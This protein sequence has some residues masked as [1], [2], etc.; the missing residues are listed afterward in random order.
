MG[1]DKFL[2]AAVLRE[3]ITPALL[4]LS[5]LATINAA[6]FVPTCSPPFRW[7]AAGLCG[8]SPGS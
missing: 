5:W 3:A 4:L 1:A 2:D 7:T 8:R 6:V